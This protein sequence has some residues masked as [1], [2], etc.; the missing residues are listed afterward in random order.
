M[1]CCKRFYAS[2]IFPFLLAKYFYG[3]DG[4]VWEM[5]PP[6]SQESINDLP[7]IKPVPS[8]FSQGPTINE[9]FGHLDSVEA[10]F[11]YFFDTELIQ[12]IV[13]YSNIRIEKKEDKITFNEM[14]AFIGLLILFGVT[15]KHDVEISEIWAFESTNQL[16]LATAAM[17]RAR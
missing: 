9:N 13:G 4:S 5:Q 2:L 15:K 8:S 12:K 10:F 3:K 7:P 11:D 6:S 1:L 14:R 17:P 16:F